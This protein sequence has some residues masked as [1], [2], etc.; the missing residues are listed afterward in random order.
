M[1]KFAL[2]LVSVLCVSVTSMAASDSPIPITP[3][4]QLILKDHH[5]KTAHGTIVTHTPQLVGAHLSAGARQFNQLVAQVIATEVVQFKQAAKKASGDNSLRIDYD[6]D[7]IKPKDITVIAMRLS[8]ETLFQHEAHPAHRFHVINYDLTH[9][10]QL[11][12]NDLFQPHSAYLQQIASYCHT[13]FNKKLKDDAHLVGQG[14]LPNAANFANWN[15]QAEG[16]LITVPA[17]QVAPYVYGK[18]EVT[19]PFSALK[20]ILAPNTVLS[21]CAVDEKNCAVT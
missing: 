3:G 21:P 6:F 12:L 10:K 9:A 18:Q 14:T 15:V 1:K 8:V 17:G 19:I 16:I 11:A 20:N 4:V 2:M 13:A 5:E 7:M